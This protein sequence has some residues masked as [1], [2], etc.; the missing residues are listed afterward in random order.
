LAR[1]A[2]QWILNTQRPDGNWG[3]D[4]KP[5]AEETAY[6][7]QALSIY[8]RHVK[9]LDKDVLKRGRAGLLACM[10]EMPPL[11]IGKCLYIPVRVVESAIYSAL[12]MTRH[13]A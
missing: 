13:L 11:W 5:T 1:S 12:T 9:P 3:H 10:N 4:D 2:I 6:C 8:D 7:L